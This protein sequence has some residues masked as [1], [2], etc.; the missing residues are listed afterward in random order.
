MEPGTRSYGELLRVSLSPMRGKVF[1]PGISSDTSKI[2]F[3]DV[4]KRLGPS[5]CSAPKA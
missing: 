3:A 5:M 4:T 1:V 2:N